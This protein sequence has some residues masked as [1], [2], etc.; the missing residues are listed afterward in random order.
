MNQPMS[1]PMFPAT[2]TGPGVGM[3]RACVQVRPTTRA[4]TSVLRASLPSRAISRM[5]PMRMTKAAS[6]NTGMEMM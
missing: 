6:K 1:A 4:V 5:R 2:A 3:T